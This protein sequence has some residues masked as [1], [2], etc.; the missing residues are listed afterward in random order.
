LLLLQT[1]EEVYDDIANLRE[2]SV[3]ALRGCIL[4]EGVFEYC[5]QYIRH[6]TQV[7]GLDTDRIEGATGEVEFI[8]EA[9]I[10]V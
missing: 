8:T 7:R 1:V 10:H 4:A 6:G 5:A 9:H 2:V 3:E